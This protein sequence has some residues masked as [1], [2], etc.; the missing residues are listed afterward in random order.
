MLLLQR[1]RGFT[2]RETRGG[3][4]LTLL[5]KE[6]I[7]SR[8]YIVL[9]SRG[10]AHNA[11]EAIILLLFVSNLCSMRFSPRVFALSKFSDRS[12]DSFE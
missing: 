9:M 1:F 4:V 12:I 7:V 11:C 8:I 5:E 6:R 10:N 2:A 3:H